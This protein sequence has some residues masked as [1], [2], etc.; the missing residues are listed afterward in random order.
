MNKYNTEEGTSPREN[1]QVDVH[2]TGKGRIDTV[3]VLQQK[4]IEKIEK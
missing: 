1:S 2:D 4:N 3:D